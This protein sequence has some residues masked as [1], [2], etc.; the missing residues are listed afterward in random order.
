QFIASHQ[1]ANGSWT[2]VDVRPPQA[3]STFTT[4]AV[5]ARAIKSY[6][7][8]QFVKERESRIQRAR[9]WLLNAEP[10]TTEDLTFRLLGLQ[11]TGADARVVKRAAQQLIA[12]QAG[13]GGWSQLRG[14]QSDAYSTGQAL[15]ALQESVGLPTDDPIYH[16]GLPFLLNT[17]EEDGSWHVS[18]RFHP[19]APVSPP[20]F[21]TGFPYKHDQFISAMGTSWAVSAILRAVPASSAQKTGGRMLDIA[22]AEQ[23]AW[24]QV[25]LN[26]SADELKKLLD[27]GM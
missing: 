26:G 11:W 20:Y 24:A 27:A 2:S 13:D 25:A 3:Y 8:E 21:E 7:P 5:C 19:P 22:P 18:S 10:R 16:R 15:S 9:A 17:Q 6:L 12:E 23:P 4:T 1:L 14:M